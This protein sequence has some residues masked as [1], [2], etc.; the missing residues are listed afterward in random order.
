[1]SK[2]LTNLLKDQIQD[3][4]ILLVANLYLLQHLVEI[5]GNIK[6]KQITIT[7]AGIL[8]KYKIKKIL[9]IYK[10]LGIVI[11]IINIAILGFLLVV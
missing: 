8:L 2:Q 1:M 3:I 11:L 4:F 5:Y 10:I 9:F 6:L 7:L